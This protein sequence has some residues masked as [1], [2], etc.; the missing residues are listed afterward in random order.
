MAYT[1]RLAAWITPKAASAS[2]STLRGWLSY[3][4]GKQKADS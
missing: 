3:L 1:D 2:D 4:L